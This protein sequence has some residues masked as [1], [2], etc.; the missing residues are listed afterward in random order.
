[1][2]E[3]TEMLSLFDYLGKPAGKE[4]GGEVVKAAMNHSNYI[5]IKR[6]YITTKFYDGEVNLFP[7]EFLNEYFNKLSTSDNSD[8]NLPF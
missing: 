4:L 3:N 1:M 2:S 5:P 7:R 8:S 6:R